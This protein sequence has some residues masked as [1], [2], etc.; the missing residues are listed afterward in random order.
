MQGGY[1]ITN[2]ANNPE[3]AFRLADFIY[4]DEVTLRAIFGR[5]AQE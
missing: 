2:K 4:S 5:P 1:A 3:A